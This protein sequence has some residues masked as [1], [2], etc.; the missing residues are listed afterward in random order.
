MR[1]S[2]IKIAGKEYMLCMS[3]RVLVDLESNGKSLENFLTDDQKTITNICWLLQ[4]M[5]EAGRVYA[6]MAGLGDYPAISEEQILDASGSD[7]YDEYM[8]AIIEAASGERKVE[9]EPP[10]NVEDTHGE[11]LN[12]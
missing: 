11:G 5:S 7:D 4:R 8:R 10:K 6:K 9:A 1:T 12:A 3:N 2:Y